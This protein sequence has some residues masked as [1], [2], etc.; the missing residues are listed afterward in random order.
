MKITQNLGLRYS[1]SGDKGNGEIV[2]YSDASH[3]DGDNGKS[4]LGHVVFLHSFPISW[5][6]KLSAGQAQSA[7]ES[8]IFGV[9]GAIREAMWTYYVLQELLLQ[10]PLPIVLYCDNNPAIQTCQRARVTEQNKHIKPKYFFVVQLVE[11]GIVDIQ[12][13][14][15]AEQIAD[16]LTKSLGN[17]QFSQLRKM[18]HIC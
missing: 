18:M 9:N 12:H 1:Q 10:D 16:I 17:P 7:M 8:E 6:S 11:K 5:C 15:S 4:T 3:N 14:P 13:V 2:A